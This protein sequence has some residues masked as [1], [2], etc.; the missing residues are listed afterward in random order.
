MRPKKITTVTYVGQDSP[1]SSHDQ[2]ILSEGSDLL[3]LCASGALL[4]V[5]LA[6]L[7]VS[8]VHHG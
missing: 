8:V 3:C 6:M 7:V 4:I 1:L 2:F 5:S